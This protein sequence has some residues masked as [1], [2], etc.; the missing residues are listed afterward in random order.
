GSTGNAA[1]DAPRRQDDDTDG[2]GQ[3]GGAPLR[4]PEHARVADGEPRHLGAPARH[5]GGRPP[6]QPPRPL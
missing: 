2:R 3:L 4:R 5:D 1:A 6:T